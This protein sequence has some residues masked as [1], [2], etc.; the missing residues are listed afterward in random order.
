MDMIWKY[1]NM[2]WS[3]LNCKVPAWAVI[4]VALVALYL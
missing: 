1:V 4:I 2:A 3:W